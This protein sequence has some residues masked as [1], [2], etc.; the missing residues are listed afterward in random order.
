MTTPPPRTVLLTG[1]TGFLGPYVAAALRANGWSVRAALRRPVRD[2][3][4][5]DERVL[6]GELGGATDWTDALIGIDAVVHLAGRAHRPPAVQLAEKE[7][8]FETNTTGTTHLAEAAAAAGVRN[9]IFASSVA[10]NGVSTDGRGPFRESD[11]PAPQSIYGR[12]KAVA[13][14]GLRN[15]AAKTGMAVA[16]IRPP[17][18]YGANAKGSFRTL[19]RAI[20]AHVP[21][22]FGMIRNRRAFVAAENVASFVAFRLENPVHGMESYIVS[23]QEQISTADFSRRIGRALDRNVMLLPVSEKALGLMLRFSGAA[24]LIESVLHSLVVDTSKVDCSGWEPAVSLDEG[25][26]LALGKTPRTAEQQRRI[27]PLGP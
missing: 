24:H 11:A 27:E 3:P 16:A 9:F 17:M 8:Y 21:L 20:A 26:L 14:D 12:T 2:L 7:L 4:A 25:L 23:D 5:H 13:E 15:V 6:I 18:I 19:S 10:V 1:I 22:P